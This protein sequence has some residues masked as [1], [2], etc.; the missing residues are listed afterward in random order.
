MVDGLSDLRAVHVPYPL[1]TDLSA[2]VGAVAAI[3]TI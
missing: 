2:F 3:L 1:S